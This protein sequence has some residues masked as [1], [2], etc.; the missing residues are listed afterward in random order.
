MDVILQKD[1][2][3]LGRSGEVVKVDDD[4]ARTYL[5][6]SR[7]AVPAD[8]TSAFLRNLSGPIPGRQHRDGLD[9]D[10]RLEINSFRELLRRA[11]VVFGDSKAAEEWM[12]EEIPSLGGRQPIDMIRGSEQEQERVYTILGRIEAGIF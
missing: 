2:E 5:L 6:P 11:T 8:V 1:V 3:H 4:L 7:L 9:S 10:A 12:H